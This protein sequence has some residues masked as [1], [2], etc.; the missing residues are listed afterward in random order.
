MN[1]E[2]GLTRAMSTEQEVE[3]ALQGDEELARYRIDVAVEG[4]TVSLSG[5]VG[6]EAVKRRA[7]QVAGSVSGVIE[8]T[9]ELIV[10]GSDM[11]DGSLLGRR[12]DDR[13]TGAADGGVDSTVGLGAIGATNSG[14]GGASGG[15]AANSAS[16]FAAAGLGA[17]GALG[18]ESAA[19]DERDAET[20]S[21]RNEETV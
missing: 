20:G 14:F 11:G 17:A 12:R 18:V 15:G 10:T 8:V 13:D 16:P 6:S 7:E 3:R 19:E 4:S 5:Q 21:R 2:G 9:N 1:N